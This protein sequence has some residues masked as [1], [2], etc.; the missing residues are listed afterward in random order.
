MESRWGVGREKKVVFIQTKNIASACKLCGILSSNAAK[1]TFV[2][3]YILERELG[4]ILGGVKTFV[5]L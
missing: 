2:G 1:K 4:L 5:A 3:M